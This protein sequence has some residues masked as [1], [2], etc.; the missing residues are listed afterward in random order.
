[1][2]GK[3]TVLKLLDLSASPT[4]APTG[5]GRKSLFHVKISADSASN[6]SCS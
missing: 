2:R 4:S 3:F 5:I 6:K 1:L